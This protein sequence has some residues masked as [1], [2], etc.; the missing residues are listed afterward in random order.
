[1]CKV[2]AIESTNLDLGPT[3][4]YGDLVYIFENSRVSIWDREFSQSIVDEL[5]V[6]GFDPTRDYLVMTG[7]IVPLVLAVAAAVTAWGTIKLLLWSASERHYTEREVGHG[8]KN[9]KPVR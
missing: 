8:S 9:P 2:F 6:L 5:F 7:H 1:M 3:R 4:E